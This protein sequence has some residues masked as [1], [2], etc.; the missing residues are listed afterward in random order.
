MRQY[1]ALTCIWLLSLLLSG[2]PSGQIADPP[3]TPTRVAQIFTIKVPTNGRWF[4]TGIKIAQGQYVTIRATGNVTTWET[5]GDIPHIFCADSPCHLPR[6]YYGE[7]IGR[8]A[9]STPFRIYSDF[10]FPAPVSGG[11]FLLFQEWSKEDSI[12]EVIVAVTVQ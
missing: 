12:G 9:G 3:G 4:D 11:L 5:I 7:L 2:C 1:F 8:F 10:D 6:A